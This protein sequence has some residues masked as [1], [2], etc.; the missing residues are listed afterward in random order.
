MTSLAGLIAAE[1]RHHLFMGFAHKRICE[2]CMT[3]FAS[4]NWI[5]GQGNRDF[6]IM[7]AV[8]ID[9]ARKIWVIGSQ[10]VTRVV[11]GT[12]L[13][14]MT[15]LAVLRNLGSKLMAILRGVWGVGI[16]ILPTVGVTIGT[17]NG[18]A[19]MVAMDRLCQ[20]RQINAQI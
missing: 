10:Q 5:G 11:N 4:A 19:L 8:T 18:E 16:A 2:R 9:T 20:C 7:S 12:G 1:T 15:L 3:A 13:I 6:S 14:G 17:G